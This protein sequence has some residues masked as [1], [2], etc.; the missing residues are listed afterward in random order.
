MCVPHVF[1]LNLVGS[2]ATAQAMNEKTKDTNELIPSHG[3]MVEML[4]G[5]EKQQKQAQFHEDCV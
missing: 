5:V 1:E 3:S 2:M 4:R